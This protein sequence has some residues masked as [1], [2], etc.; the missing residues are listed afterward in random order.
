M[1]PGLITTVPS[2]ASLAAVDTSSSLYAP[3]QLLNWVYLT[4][5]DQNSAPT[6]DQ[7]PV[8]QTQILVEVM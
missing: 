2:M 7:V 3:T 4:L 5:A 1:A 6:T 8:S